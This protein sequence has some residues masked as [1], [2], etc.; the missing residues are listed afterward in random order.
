MTPTSHSHPDS[1]PLDREIEAALDGVDLQEIRRADEEPA[2][3]GR[4]R[5]Y[6]GVVAGVSGDDVIVELG[7]R[8]QGVVS[9]REFE[10]P[11]S[12]G[13]RHRFLLRGREDDLWILSLREA[14][15]I[16]AWDDIEPGSLVRA[17]VSGQNQGGLELKIGRHDAFMPASQVTVGREEDIA[18]FLGQTLVCEVLEVDKKRGRCV[19]SRRRVQERE[20][21]EALQES[22]GKLHAGM[23]VT[24]KVSRMESFGA[25][26]DLGN[27]VEG[28]LHVSNVSRR[29]VSDPKEVLTEGQEVRVQVLEIKEN[30][31]RIGLGMKQLE[32]D[33]WDDVEA[34]YH[35][36]AQVA[37]RV[38]RIT[39]F[40]AF[41]ELE[42]GLEGL[43]HVSQL[44]RERVRRVDEV[45]KLGDEVTVRVQGVDAPA[46][47]LSLSRLDS[48]GALL[49][50]DEAVDSDVIDAALAKP[51]D[52]GLRTNL[53]A[54]FRRALENKER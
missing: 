18:S 28:L 27:G 34:R 29:R 32:P 54:L 7:P 45:L 9:T 36:D 47:R 35:A 30:G 52:E 23:V 25:F 37:G 53:G 4:D 21:Q 49:G 20:R 39:D 46:R 3:E 15:E 48:R 44:G 14:Q 40:G 24:G 11:P 5:L 38:V 51:G 17:R 1:D 41:I 50:S 12:V 6:P 16:A 33:P 43:L 19:V 31:R 8:M 2:V 26:V 13:D 42:P 10:T 22:L